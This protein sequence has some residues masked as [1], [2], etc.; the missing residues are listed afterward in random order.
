[1]MT[2]MTPYQMERRVL[3]LDSAVWWLH[4]STKRGFIYYLCGFPPRED[5]RRSFYNGWSTPIDVEENGGG[6]GGE[7]GDKV[8]FGW[9]GVCGGGGEKGEEKEEV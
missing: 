1:M 9:D 6:R 8:D 3:Y 5:V 2:D 7:R 4:R